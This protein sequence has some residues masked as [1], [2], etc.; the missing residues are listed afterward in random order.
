MTTGLGVPLEERVE[1]VSREWISAADRF[2]SDRVASAADSLQGVR[3]AFGERYSNAPPHL[4]WADDVAGFTV[5]IEDSRVEV[6][7][8]PP[9]GA[10]DLLIEGDYNATLPMAW[11][12]FG[13]DR[14][15]RARAIREYSHMAGDK[16]P[17]FTG[18]LKAT[19][20]AID[21]ILSELHDHL[22]RRTINNP[23]IDHRIEHYGLEQNAADLADG[24]WTV[25]EG[26]FT[27]EFAT[28]L[29]DEINRNHDGQPADSGFRA[30]MLLARGRFWEEAAVHPWVLTLAEHLL[31]R[32]CLISQSDSIRKTAGQE[33][34]P[35]LHA[36]YSAWMVQEPFPEQC[37]EATAVWAIDDFTP[38][39]GPTVLIPGSFRNRKMAPADATR[40]GTIMVEMPKGSIAFWHGATWHGAAPRTADGTRVSL[41]N[42]Y[43][44][45]FVR[46][47]ERYDDLPSEIIDR[48]PPVFSTLCGLDDL[49]GKSTDTGADFERMMYCR[50]AGYGRRTMA[51]IR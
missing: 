12:P 26:A 22:A 47:I 44:R 16:A 34:H 10:V 25:L 40:D 15:I 36:D 39:A 17:I 30:T 18:D 50:A 6:H 14:S 27:D 19:P 42:S 20:P 1:F 23:D 38:E 29:R 5:F 49:F 2:L 21:T 33:T 11:T 51:P 7:H 35:G 24:G 31:G 46:T 13:D 41:H 43:T 48:N 45:N 37:L 4:D 8:R 3:F 9:I 28:E 32:G